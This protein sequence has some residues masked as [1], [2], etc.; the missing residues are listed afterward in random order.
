MK[1]QIAET[2]SSLDKI[3]EESGEQKGEEW[4]YPCLPSNESNYLP[5]ILF[6]FPPF[7]PKEDGSF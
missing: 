4:I 2:G 3:E 6:D 7:L 5:L 1:E